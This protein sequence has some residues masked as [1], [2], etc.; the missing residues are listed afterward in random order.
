MV[1]RVGWSGS[2]SERGGGY[3]SKGEERV[4]WVGKGAWL[5]CGG[6]GQLGEG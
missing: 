2:G 4:L 5:E 6:S 1:G 3:R